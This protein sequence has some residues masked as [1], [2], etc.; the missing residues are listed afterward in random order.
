MPTEIDKIRELPQPFGSCPDA[1]EALESGDDTERDDAVEYFRDLYLAYQGSHHD[2]CVLFS[3]PK[4][5]KFIDEEEGPDEEHQAALADV[6]F[7]YG[8]RLETH[9]PKPEVV[10]ALRKHFPM[11]LDPPEA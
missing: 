5:A 7:S 1:L 3:L 6:L 11:A 4:L 8:E 2:A 9:S 10:A